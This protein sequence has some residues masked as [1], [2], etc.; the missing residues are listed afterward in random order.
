M[1]VY[2]RLLED[3]QRIAKVLNFLRHQLALYNDP[4]REPSLNVVMEALDYIDAYPDVVHH[5]LEEIAFDAMEQR[6]IGDV[7]AIE[8]LREQHKVLAEKTASLRDLF[9][10]ILQDHPVPIE[11]VAEEL[12]DYV[13]LQFDHMNTEESEILPRMQA[14]FSES[15]WA[16]IARQVE[17]RPDP[18]FEDLPSESFEELSR[19][20]A[21]VE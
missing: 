9:E 8:R 17:Q 16:E 18:L 7:G 6:G 5:P 13:N 11:K 15:D 2:E 14:E 19:E 3:H 21:Q 20:M 4:D 1:N 10:S 12:T